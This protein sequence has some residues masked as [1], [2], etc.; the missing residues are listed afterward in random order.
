FLCRKIWL[1][2]VAVWRAA[3]CGRRESIHGGFGLGFLPRTPAARGPPDGD[4]RCASPE[5]IYASA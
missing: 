1:R 3:R 4:L 5:R 2:F